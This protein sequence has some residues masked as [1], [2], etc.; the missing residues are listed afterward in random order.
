[1]AIQMRRGLRQDFDPTQMVAGEWAVS[2]DSSTSNRIVWMCFGAGAVKRMGT[3]EDFQAMIGEITDDIRDDMLAIEAEVQTLADAVGDDKDAVASMKTAIEQTDLPA[4]QDYVTTCQTSAQNASLSASNA[5]GSATQASAS[6]TE[7]ESWAHGGTGTRQGEDT[8]NARYWAERAQSASFQQSDW[9]EDDPTNSSYIAHKPFN[10]VGAG[11]HVQ[12][13]ALIA[14]GVDDYDDLQNKPQINGH[15]LTGNKTI[16]DLGIPTKTSDLQNDSGFITDIP[17]ATPSTAGKVKPDGST[18]TVDANGALTAHGGMEWDGL[19]TSLRKN[20]F[21]LDKISLKHNISNAFTWDYN[22]DGTI[23]FNGV[24]QNSQWWLRVQI[25][26]NDPHNLYNSGTYIMGVDFGEHTSLTMNVV[27]KPIGSSEEVTIASYPTDSEFTIPDI[28]IYSYVDYRIYMNEP[29]TFDNYVI[30]PMLRLASISDNR[31][32]PFVP[33]NVELA[34]RIVKKGEEIGD[35][36]TFYGAKNILKLAPL[37]GRTEVINGVTFTVN[38]DETVTVNG[39][40][41]NN[42]Y[43]TLCRNADLPSNTDLIL[44]GTPYDASNNNDFSMTYWKSGEMQR[45]DTGRGIT[46]QAYTP[47]TGKDVYLQLF[48]KSGYT[49]DNLLFKPMIRLATIVDDTFTPYAMTNSKITDALQDIDL[50]YDPT[51]QEPQWKRRGADTWNPFSGGGS[52][53][54]KATVTHSGPALPTK[55][56]DENDNM[57]YANGASSDFNTNIR[58]QTPAF[59]VW[60]IG[61]GIVRIET[62][63][64]CYIDNVLIQANTQFRSTYMYNS[65]HVTEIVPVWS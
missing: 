18:I 41:T 61:G 36:A 15:T 10:T 32:T 13:G 12:N 46:F 31:Y 64:D 23:T 20:L 16:A 58:M 55:C 52:T 53:F 27:G 42:I 3:Y 22:K 37:G 62:K 25:S 54:A 35:I 34:E 2:V 50:R 30:K 29:Q 14:D 56:Y 5:S 44:T 11:L 45:V 59:D 39:T 38:D 26:T 65:G 21:D 6:A 7:A 49:A 24:V 17:L 33:D 40:A 57:L 19:E 43:F 48:V 63:L 1:M 47:E 8:N 60:Y 51:T 9:T 28:S 4:I